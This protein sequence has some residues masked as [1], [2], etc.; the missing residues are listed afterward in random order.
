MQYSSGPYAWPS[1]WPSLA[2]VAG[3]RAQQNNQQQNRRDQE[4][5]SQAGAARH[6]GARADWSTPSP[7]ASSRRRPTSPLRWDAQPFRQGA[8]TARPT[9]RS[10]S[11]SI[12]SKLAVA[13]RRALRPRRQQERRGGRAPRPPPSRTTATGTSRRRPRRRIRGTTSTSSTCRP[14]GKVSRAMALKPGEYEVFI[15]VKEREPARAAAQRAARQ[16]RACCAATSR[17]PTSTA[18]PQHEPR[19]SSRRDR[20]GD[21]RR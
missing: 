12:A 6:R 19:A 14:T 3:A 17:C 2:G 5:R 15:A 1:R 13:G 11:R 16:G 10:P 21:R 8:A 7:P 20:A 9:S 18:R 4:R